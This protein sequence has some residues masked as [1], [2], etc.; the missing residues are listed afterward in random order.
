MRRMMLLSLAFGALVVSSVPLSAEVKTVKGEIVDQ[1]CF[2]KD[3]TNRGADHADCTSS[4]LKKGKPAAVVT[5]DG[6]VYLI[7]GKY[8][9]NKNAKLMEFASKT[10][11]I[12]GDVTETGGTKSINAESVSASKTGTN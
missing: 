8:A 5:E 2:M 11:E 4:C 3:K 6:Q 12:K 1:A 9:E 10:V 7:T